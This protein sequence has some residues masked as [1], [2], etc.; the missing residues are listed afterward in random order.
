MLALF[1]KLEEF[2]KQY[3]MDRKGEYIM[4]ILGKYIPD[5]SLYTNECL[6]NIQSLYNSIHANILSR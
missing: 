6:L 5:P 1:K 3:T 2:I 4:H